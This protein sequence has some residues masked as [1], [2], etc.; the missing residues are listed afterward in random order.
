MIGYWNDE[1]RT[2]NT[3]DPNG[4]MMSGDLGIMDNEGYLRISGRVKDLIIRGGENITP[5]EIENHL[6]KHENVRDCQ[7]V[8][9]KDKKMGEE[10]C[11]W[12]RVREMAKGFTRKDLEEHCRGR[13]AHFKIPR[14]I[15]VCEE[16]PLTV[17]GKIKKNLLRDKSDKMLENGEDLIN[18]LDP[19]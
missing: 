11:A 9:V 5:A 6:M 8:G 18:G 17:T 1:E 13:I 2:K 15:G 16:Y 10:I 4:W 3:I 14:Y 7:V 12:I 19:E